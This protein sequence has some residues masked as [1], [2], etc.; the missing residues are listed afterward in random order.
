MTKKEAECLEHLIFCDFSSSRTALIHF[1]FNMVFGEFPVKG[2]TLAD[3]VKDNQ[4][5]SC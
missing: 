1:I 2:K 4:L 5:V 3:I